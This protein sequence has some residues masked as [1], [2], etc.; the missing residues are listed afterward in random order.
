MEDII[1]HIDLA[2]SCV[3]TLVY[4][5]LVFISVLMP[6]VSFVHFSQLVDHCVT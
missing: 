1:G 5:R 2:R 4:T 3:Y 6:S